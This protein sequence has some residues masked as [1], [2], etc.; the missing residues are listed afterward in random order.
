MKSNISYEV[1]AVKEFECYYIK[2]ILSYCWLVYLARRDILS[3]LC[4]NSTL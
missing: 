4:R 3:S 1:D 2:Y